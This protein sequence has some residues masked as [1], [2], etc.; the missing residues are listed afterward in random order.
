MSAV[1]PMMCRKPDKA[2][3]VRGHVKQTIASDRSQCR[4]DASVDT[5]D[6]SAQIRISVALATAATAR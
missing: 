1:D 5:L 4:R 6:G 2:Q 3:E